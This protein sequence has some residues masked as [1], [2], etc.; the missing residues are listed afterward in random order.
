MKRLGM[1]ALVLMLLLSAC[2][3]A[4]TPGVPAERQVVI[5]Y[6]RS[7]GIAGIHE[8]WLIYSDGS[9]VSAEGRG[10]T[11]PA[12]EV[13]ALL[14][15][16]EAAGFF[17]WDEVYQPANPCCDRMTHVLTVTLNDKTHHVQV[18]DATESAPSALFELID[19]V[20]ALIRKASGG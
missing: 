10:G 18:L 3:R 5:T 9:V 11:V 7:G 14:Q 16:I 17:T 6:E 8:R 12:A 1:I 4:A 20:N 19:A 13:T 15:R 2:G